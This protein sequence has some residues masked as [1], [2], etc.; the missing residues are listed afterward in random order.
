MTGSEKGERKETK[1][2]VALS[3]KPGRNNAPKVVASGRGIVAEKIM[4]IARE[5]DIPFYSDPQL[6]E[7]LIKLDLSQEIPPE[8]YRVIAE[9][10]VFV[11]QMDRSFLDQDRGN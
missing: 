2:A 5:N 7:T 11:Y 8:L 3:Y 6:V 4:E 1:K 9:V 10:L